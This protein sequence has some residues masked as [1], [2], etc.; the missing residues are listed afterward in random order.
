MPGYDYRNTAAQLMRAG[1]PRTT[2]C[3]IISQATSSQEQIHLTTVEDL[4]ESPRL[5]A[6][7]LLVVGEVVRWAKPAVLREQFA[8]R[9]AAPALSRGEVGFEAKADQERAE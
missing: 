7:T 4:H 3:A 2:P 8:W 1:L 6:P 9:R 5:P